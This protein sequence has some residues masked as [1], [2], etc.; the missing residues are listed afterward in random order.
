MKEKAPNIVVYIR[1]GSKEQLDN[2]PEN[3]KNPLPGKGAR[4][5][6]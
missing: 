1:V 2:G 3:K 5:K 6:G 4:G